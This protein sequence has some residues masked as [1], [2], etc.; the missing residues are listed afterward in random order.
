M[1]NQIKTC[2]RESGADIV[3][4]QEVLGEHSTHE[5]TIEGWPVESQFEF[6]ADSVWPHFAYGKN[7]VYEEGHHG[8]AI[9]SRFPIVSFEN[10][11]IST[12]RFEKRGCLHAVVDC[13]AQPIHV[14][15]IHLNLF[16]R[17]RR[18]QFARIAE[19]IKTGI[20]LNEPVILA[21]DFNDWR[22][23]ASQSLEV[24]A[25]LKEAFMTL[26]GKHPKTFPSLFPVLHLDRLYLRQLTPIWGE[27]LGGPP[28]NQL[29]D[30]SAIL[31]ELT[32]ET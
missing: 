17:G 29:S 27:V 7:A 1:L 8:N 6:L 28:W 18:K 21:G 25:G 4:L 2:I 9:L 12:N 11:D 31:A 5:K 20:P 32:L 24:D 10:L 22:E 23:R 30:H 3:C 26:Y 13:E 14:M 19:R 16:E 15:N